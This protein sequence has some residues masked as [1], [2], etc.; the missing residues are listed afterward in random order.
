MAKY[1][2]TSEPVDI[3]P[4]LAEE[5]LIRILK[6]WRARR[7][8]SKHIPSDNLQAAKWWMAHQEERAVGDAPKQ[9][10]DKNGEVSGW[11]TPY[12]DRLAYNLRKFLSL[13]EPEKAYVIHNIETGIPWRGD[14]TDFYKMVVAEHQKMLADPDYI[15]RAKQILED[16]I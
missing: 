14:N 7:G 3:K 1:Q 4:P 12:H 10:I 15:P 16:V 8:Y 5:V 11:D 13:P 6:S 2:G 9:R